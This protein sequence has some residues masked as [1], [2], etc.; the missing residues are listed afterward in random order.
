MN[1]RLV[2]ISGPL[3]GS[4]I[5]I[6]ESGLY[7]GRGRRNQ[8][9]L[10]DPLVASRQ[11][12]IGSEDGRCML[13]ILNSVQAIFVN[14]FC[15]CG[16]ILVQGDHIRLG[17]SIL[18]FLTDEGFDKALLNLTDAEK[19]WN[20][21]L[22]H[23]PVYQ[24]AT[25]TA[26]EALVRTSSEINAIR[27]PD[28]IQARVAGLIFR[29]IPVEGVAILLAGHDKDCFVSARYW[30][31]GSQNSDP[32]PVDETAS[33]KAL[34]EGTP[35]TGEKLICCP[36]TALDTK[37]GVI[38]TV[39]ATAGFE[40]VL[41]EHVRLLE[42]IAG[43]AALALEHARYVEW[44]EGE[45]RRLKEEL[46]L[47]HGMIGNSE[48]MKEV[49]QFIRRVGPTE[50]P[51]LLLGPSGTGKELAAHAVYRNSPRYGKPFLAVNCGAFTEALLQSELFGHEKGS[52]TGATTQKKG[53]FE[54]ANGGTLFLDE[55]G[56]LPMTM[57]ADLLRVLQ[58][59][60]F[61][62]VGGT[63][64][65]KADVRI[66]AATNRNLQEAIKEGRFREDLFFRLN[67]FP[68][69]MPALS[70]RR[71]DIPL[72]AA[73]FI[74]KHRHIR[75][76][77]YPPVAGITPEAH[78]I[79]ASYS[80]P[81]NVRELEN[82]IQWA[83]SLGESPYIRPEELPKEVEAC[84]GS[85]SKPSEPGIYQKELAAFQRLLFKRLLQENQGDYVKAAEQLA[86]N[87]KYFRDRCRKLNLTWP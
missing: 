58:N 3:E 78:H 57:Q 34:R 39:M 16:K 13:V 40:Y 69:V 37:V 6:P 45:N 65:L 76:G 25:A 82:V 44:L 63:A 74:K 33:L 22:E 11:C 50:R 35:V 36:M 54:E 29:V 24:A 20:R 4:V 31:L 79:L 46:D 56:E 26:F 18:V 60:E 53:I 30:H 14:D 43:S 72:L 75:K 62:R 32:F 87:P 84:C 42:S 86:F 12:F 7:I 59:Q 19:S 27:S 67:V 55:I 80:W 8:V 61:K 68:L 71:E 9:R 73:H 5:P 38:Y 47:E 23:A 1:P 85:E 52:F 51:V 83:I 49:Y 70:E 41:G 66:I 28:E 15:V 81:G 21:S 17:R 64:T 48:K 10:D 77:Q 2:A